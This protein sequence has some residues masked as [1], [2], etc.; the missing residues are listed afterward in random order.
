MRILNL[1][2]VDA[3]VDLLMRRNE[4]GVSVEVLRRRGEI[5][6]VETL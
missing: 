5:E 2:V 3:T 1:R 4:D 6:I